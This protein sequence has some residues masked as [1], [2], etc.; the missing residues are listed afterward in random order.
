MDDPNEVELP[1]PLARPGHRIAFW[2]LALIFMGG[3]VWLHI[4][5]GYTFPTPWADEVAYLWQ[6]IALAR[7]GSPV[8]PELVPNTHLMWI[9]PGFMVV[10]AL[11]FRALGFSLDLAR[12]LSA[13]EVL[14]FFGALCGVA[15]R[16]RA[17]ISSLVLSG[18]FLWSARFVLAGNI[19]RM[20][21]LVLCF[22]GLGLVLQSRG[23]LV[24]GL[25]L[26]ACAP[27]VHPNGVLFLA[28]A[29]AFV[30]LQPDL[31][32][33]LRAAGRRQWIVLVVVVCFY[34]GWAIYTAAHWTEF[35]MQM[36]AQF[37]RKIDRDSV[38]FAFDLEDWSF[39][40]LAVAGLV[41]GFRRHA[42]ATLLCCYSIGAWLTYSIGLEMWYLVNRH[43]GVLFLALAAI[44]LAQVMRMPER[45]KAF[46]APGIVFALLLAFWLT[47]TLPFPPGDPQRLADTRMFAEIKPDW[48][49]V[50]HSALEKVAERLALY[51][52]CHRRIVVR[53]Y[54]R[55]D[56]LL[57][58][59]KLGGESAIL[60]SAH[61]RVFSS[62][63]ERDPR[64]IPPDWDAYVIHLTYEPVPYS[65]S[66]RNLAFTDAEIDSRSRDHLVFFDGPYEQWYLRERLNRIGIKCFAPPLP[67]SE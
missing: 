59:E 56:S 11:F 34:M 30:L 62:L 15:R 17:P 57:L 6:G 22:V 9:P 16:L 10:N 36:G 46:V 66:E 55:A 25:A 26:A 49:R 43:V 33:R 19:G 38:L 27:L 50:N 61:P 48:E 3:Y 54:P 21:A 24:S 31:A 37:N 42:L 23:R 53:V 40:A 44:E 20:E 39:L 29:V 60:F 5:A 45:A 7:S 13:G 52:D 65:L 18:L 14:V 51:N 41:W 2:L 32:A 58:Y 35:T 12:W 64:Y 63:R 67:A 8:A 1:D 4:R 28:A 47:N